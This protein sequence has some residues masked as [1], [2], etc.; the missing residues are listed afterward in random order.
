MTL[1]GKPLQY[2]VFCAGSFTA[3]LCGVHLGWPSP[4]LPQLLHN[5]STI[6]LTNNEGSWV[7]SIL[8]IG[9]IFGA[10][11][12]ALTLDVFGRKSMLI[13]T[14]LP[15]CV[16]WLMIAFARSVW[17]L[18]IARFLAGIS[19]GIIFSCLPLYLAEICDPKIRG[20]LISGVTV[21]YLF[22]IFLANLVGAFL[23][24]TAAALI[25]SILSLGAI[26]FAVFIPESPQFYLMK[27]DVKSAKASMQRFNDT[28]NVDDIFEPIRN[29]LKEKED[30]KGKWLQLFTDASNRK[31]LGLIIGLRAFQQCTGIMGITFYVHTLFEETEEDVS[32]IVFVSIFFILQIAVSIINSAIIDKLGRKPLLITSMSMVVVALFIVSIYFTLENVSHVQV[33]DFSWLPIFG[34]FLFI[35]GYTVALHNVP[36]VLSGEIF[37]LHI[38]AYAVG[39]MDIFYG[40]F[41][42]LV[43]KL[44]QYSK[45]EFGMHV[46][47]IAFTIIS[48]CGLPFIIFCVPET[49]RKTLEEIQDRLRSKPKSKSDTV[50]Q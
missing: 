41:S 49:K 31:S 18:Y 19:D 44:F 13:V 7:A 17:E 25:F 28:V 5:N 20:V 46:P 8:L 42:A 33:D 35:I 4:S 38:R 27:G 9:G 21:V 6:P 40:L 2:F 39:A 36:I 29:S 12:S 1:R 45:D 34:L 22:G 10:I 50:R 26:L 14:S 23:N 15:L 30:S 24:V 43:S 3:L 48:L 47:F 11:L 32:P 16:T 37:S